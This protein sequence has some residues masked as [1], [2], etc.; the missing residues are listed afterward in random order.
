MFVE[1][2]ARERLALRPVDLR[3]R[4]EQLI[5]V[6][7]ADDLDLSARREIAQQIEHVGMPLREH[8]EQV[9]LHLDAR[10]PRG[11]GGVQIQHGREALDDDLI[12][13][14]R[15]AMLRRRTGKPDEAAG[16]VLHVEVEHRQRVSLD[17]RNRRSVREHREREPEHH[18]GC[19]GIS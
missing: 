6:V 19:H 2:R 17:R 4:D 13:D 1:R 11:M 16:D 15:R 12:L 14:V 8:V 18:R 3:V 9:A 7:E 5:G 10:A